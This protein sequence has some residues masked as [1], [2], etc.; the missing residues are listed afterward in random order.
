MWP[1][2]LAGVAGVALQ[3]GQPQLWPGW[4]YGCVAAA[5]VV[6]AGAALG[7]Y[8]RTVRFTSGV[9]VLA[10]LGVGLLA[11]A[12]T[13]ARALE[14]QQDR[15]ALG[16]EGVDLVLVGE[17]VGLPRRT[18][19]GWRVVVDT[20]SALRGGESVAVPS[21]VQLL[22]RAPGVLP[23]PGQR[24]QWPVRLQAPHG[25][26]NP[27]GFDLELW[28]WAEGQGATGQVRSGKADPVPHLVA[29]A[30]GAWVA[31]ARQQVRDRLLA[32]VSDPRAA[33]VLAALV[34]GDQ[35]S[36]DATD[37][38]VFRDT[39]VAHLVSVSGLHVTM[40]AWL[41]MAVVGVFWR[42]VARWYPAL[43]W[44]VP[45]PQAAIWGGVVLATAY[46]VFAGWGVPAQRTVLM[47]C[48]VSVLRLGGRRWPWPAVWMVA[49]WAVLCLDP[50]AL[51]QPGFWLSFV[52]VGVLM[53][54]GVPGTPGEPGTSARWGAKAWGLLREQ[55]VVTVALAPLTLLL[56][57]QF[58]VVGL[59]ANLVAIPWVT[60][61]VT[62]L[63]MLG[64]LIPPLLDWGAVAVQGMAWVLTH[65][66]AWPV[67]VVDRPALPLGLAVMAVVGGLLLVQRWPWAWRGWGLFWLWPALVYSPSPPPP[68]AFVLSVP[69]V[70]QGGAAL[71]RTTHHS[72]LFDTGPAWGVG[73]AQ[74]AG[75]RVLVPWLRAEGVRLDAVV[76]SHED[77]DHAGGVQAIAQA[78]PKAQWWASFQPELPARAVAQR[79]EAG[80]RWVWDGV[81][82]E[83]LHPRAEDY[84]AGLSS[85]AL[86]CVLQVGEGEQSVL[87]TGDITVAEETRIALGRPGLRAHVLLAAHHGSQ[88]SSGPVWLNTVQPKV[89]LVQAGH[90]NR[91]GHPA[92][93]VLA[94]YQERGIPWY[95]SPTCGAATWDSRLPHQVRC[96]RDSQRRYW[97]HQP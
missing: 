41:A 5:G 76:V 68:G 63:A 35:A 29:E 83:V 22:W 36:I 92:P 2:W 32:A 1:V 9:G 25:L 18:G 12:G 59:L 7:W 61:V 96:E 90:R 89:V 91:Y 33:G 94:R 31:R 69:D 20:V 27:G 19:T 21:Q 42:Q 15:L 74:N 44:H 81:P 80:Q 65:L 75:E 24:W 8:Q 17:V 11:F 40:F 34:V 45:V 54:S 4:G 85:N 66:A 97:H 73:P 77:L 88:T 46:A 37:W 28:M 30:S 53:A 14:R 70:G 52:A 13:G 67:A 50:W 48:V 38:A 23:V 56:F 51:L 93:V 6:L 87:L 79:C 47:L 71:V 82:F 16:L 39:G 95:S 60:L 84:S 26:R 43:L 62:P 86:S 3:L 72:L 58:S 55:A 49:M 57:G 78:H 10:A 64:M